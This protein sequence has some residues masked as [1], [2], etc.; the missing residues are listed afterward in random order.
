MKTNLPPSYTWP[1]VSTFLPALFFVPALAASPCRDN[2]QCVETP[3]FA[4]ELLDV[5]SSVE[6]ASRVLTA[7]VR[8]HNHLNRPLILGYVGNSGVA[9]DDRGNRYAVRNST[10]V[11]GLGWLGGGKVDPKFAIAA[12]ES[13]DA[14]LELHWSPQS[15]AI[16]G[17]TF[18]LEFAVREM[19]QVNPTQ[20]RLGQEFPLRFNGLADRITAGVRLSP[21]PPAPAPSP[22]PQPQPVDA[23]PAPAPASTAAPALAPPPLA[24]DACAG[25]QHC[26]ATPSFAA[27]VRQ[28]VSSTAYGR[29][30][31]RIRA[32]FRNLTQA[33]LILAYLHRS[34]KA[35]DERGAPY[36]Q[37][38]PPVAGM[39]VVNGRQA[40]ASFLLAPGQQRE[41]VFEITRHLGQQPV[42][43]AVFSWDVVVQ[44]L[45]ILPGNQVVTRQEH[46]LSFPDLEARVM[47]S[48]ARGGA[49][50]P[51]SLKDLFRKRK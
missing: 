27:T 26:Y 48:P 21:S 15:N 47:A 34:S 33:P 4:A 8:F 6:G 41:A 2:P 13:R 43:G 7:N 24:A 44:E 10:G 17:M 1:V 39:G 38:E 29:Q 25:Q 32:R 36:A 45:E 23:S 11:R 18:S 14:R 9:T 46:S 31:V 30:T 50:P 42:P 19:A 28:V 40:N 16:Y 3:A 51:A 49:P 12:G 20:Y 37:N 22:A 5:R 35:I